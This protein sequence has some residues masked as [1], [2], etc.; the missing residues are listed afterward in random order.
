LSVA[1]AAISTSQTEVFITRK[2][3]S[4]A[5]PEQKPEDEASAEMD[6]DPASQP[7]IIPPELKEELDEDETEFRSIR[8]DLPGVK[9]ASAAGIVAISVGKTPTKNEFFRTH[10]TFRPVVA[11]VNH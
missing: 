3:A 4:M 6:A 11:M 9:G 10:P 7:A 2:E 8:K 1:T 5:K